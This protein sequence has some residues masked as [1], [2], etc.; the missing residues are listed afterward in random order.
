[1]SLFTLLFIGF[2]IAA[3]ATQIGLSL[4]QI[5]HVQSH[6]GQVP[7]DFAEKL[8]LEAHQKAADYT[9][10]K[11]RFGL[12]ELLWGTIILFGWTLGGGLEW[13]D[14]FWRAQSFAGINESKIWT[15]IALIISLSLISS[16]LE[17]PFE[18][19]RSFGIEQRFG[20]N[21]QTP[22]LL[23]ADKFKGLIVGL[24]IGIPL[25]WVILWLME[26]AGDL[27]WL[28][29]WAVW[30]GFSLLLMWLFPTVIAPLFNKFSP[31][32]EDGLKQRI[33]GLLQRC[34]FKSKGVFVMD[35]S[36]RS[37]H[38][39]AYFTGFGANK[40]IVFF[41]TL[42]EQLDDEQIEAVL[43]HELGHFRLHHI[44]IR[45]ILTII[46]SL[47]ALA[48]LGWLSQQNWFYAGLG[49]SQASSY[50]ALMLFALA[51]P[52]FLFFLSPLSSIFSRRH[53]FQ[54]DA[55]AVQHSNGEALASALVKMYEENASTLTP[56]PLHSAFYDSHPPAPIRLAHL[57]AQMQSQ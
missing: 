26:G 9:V 10:T 13:L 35:G 5:K 49:L 48:V 30:T 21:R 53:E 41:D 44:R 34:G 14:Q 15:G 42:I 36:K 46:T 28:Y 19:Y 12:I 37:A 4:R 20:F 11:A 6:R 29:V 54:A 22:G 2:V 52:A 17:L 33:E 51:S 55:Y 38:G 39:N 23:I 27:W 57:H 31:L 1:M 40:R 24:I 50:G 25:L 7:A 43:A 45:L 47:I 56:D 18:L 3:L 16:V 32:P 8:P